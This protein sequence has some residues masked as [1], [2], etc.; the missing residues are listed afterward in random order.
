[1]NRMSTLNDLLYSVLE[2]GAR[3]VDW[4]GSGG[5]SD[6]RSIED[7]CRT[8][9]GSKGEASGVALASEILRRFEA[10]TRAE[11]LDFFGLLAEKFD[12][13]AEEVSARSRVY[14]AEPGV[15]T[16]AD[17]LEAAEPRRQELLRRLNF[18]PGGTAA[19]VRMR[20]ELLDL[21]PDNEALRRVD[22]DFQ[23]L[24]SSWFNRG[25]LVLQPIDWRTPAHV[26]EKIIEY[27][28]VHEIDSWDELRL[29][30]QP[31]D[32]RC[33]AFF[34]PA[35]PDEPLI[36]VEVAL[37]GEISASIETILAPSREILPP[38]DATT[39]VFYS[40]S[41]CQ[42]GL[43]GVS[44]GAFLIKQVAEDLARALPNLTTFVTLSP[45]PGF[46]RWLREQAKGG[47]NEK[48]QAALSLT[49]DLDWP[50][51]A[52]TAETLRPH[53]TGLAAQYLLEAKGRGDQ[54]LDPVARFHLGNGASLT[55]I[56]WLADR[57][58]KGLAQSYSVMVNYLY[59]LD[60]VESR[61][62]DY[63]EARKIHSSRQVRALLP[64]PGS[65]TASK[66]Q[67]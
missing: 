7:L 66:K 21:L 35:M 40:I 5:K 13:D 52:E 58:A 10:A 29:R 67:M 1:M 16:L 20:A 26:L 53:I 41:N 12:L 31:A 47:D 42:K 46:G 24:L 62:E 60:E 36:F 11:R 23:H 59:E 65:S 56:N 25:F 30:L 19:L 39:A 27:E 50:R 15:E 55:R 38:G 57:S 51:D 18:A 32:R 28:A 14:I 63:A 2:R 22:A 8:L 37:T 48:A 43:K 49:G 9:L 44:F 6:K 64:P 34:H 4:G 17:L 45:V 54:P 33:F 3:L 61:H